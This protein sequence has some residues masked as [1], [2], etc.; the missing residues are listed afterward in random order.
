MRCERTERAAL[1]N[2]CIMYPQTLVQPPSHRLIVD[3]GKS[4]T[5]LD[6]GRVIV[7]LSTIMDN[8]GCMVSSQC[9]AQVG[10]CWETVPKYGT[11]RTIMQ[12]P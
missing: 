11:R 2:S 3:V 8:T 9:G 6:D 10:E 4:G 12:D 1:G 5:L 7:N